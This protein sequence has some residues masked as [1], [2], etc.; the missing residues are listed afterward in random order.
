MVAPWQ[1]ERLDPSAIPVEHELPPERREV[2][3]WVSDETV[4]IHYFPVVV[5]RIGNAWWAGLPASYID[6]DAKRWTVTHWKP[7]ASAPSP[8]RVGT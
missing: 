1:A 8:D 5:W 2:L 4:A 3:G 6:L 7:L